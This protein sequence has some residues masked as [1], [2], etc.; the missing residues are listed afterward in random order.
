[1]AFA[2]FLLLTVPTGF[3]GLLIVV[4]A[5]AIAAAILLLVRRFSRLERLKSHHD[6]AGPLFS[7]VGVIYAVLLAFVVIILWQ[8]FDQ[9]RT[10]VISESTHFAD[11]YRD[12][13]AFPEQQTERIRSALD[14]YVTAVV[15]EEWPALQAGKRSELADSLFMEVWDCYLDYEP[16]TE[17]ETIFY[18]ESVA[19]LNEAG[20][21]RVQ[22]IEDAGAGMHRILWLTLIIGGLITIAFTSFF[23]SENFWSHLIMTSLFAALIALLI[24]IA[25]VLDYPFS[26]DLS[27]QPEPFQAMLTM[28]ENG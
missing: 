4:L 21:L 5:I 18:C 3:L 6:I 26:G 2:Q 14:D 12:A 11:L 16:H 19:K 8:N 23:G 7:T 13:A 20:E 24:F 17:S 28:I 22:R 25:L 9:A 27:I 10:D 1:M 15:E